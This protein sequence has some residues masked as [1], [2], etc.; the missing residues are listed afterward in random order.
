MSNDIGNIIRAA[1][2]LLI[3]KAFSSTGRRLFRIYLWAAMANEEISRNS[4][5]MLNA[6]ALRVIEQLE[7][8]EKIV[9]VK[10]VENILAHEMIYYS[11]VQN[12][13]MF[14]RVVS[15]VFSW[16]YIDMDDA[17]NKELRVL[18]NVTRW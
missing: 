1:R 12:I 15:G 4:L 9:P 7:G 13:F 2:L 11:D 5:D 10:T 17:L 6:S 8:E 18:L 14:D 3:T 16:N